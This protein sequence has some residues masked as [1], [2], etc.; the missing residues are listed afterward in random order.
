MDCG[1]CPLPRRTGRNVSSACRRAR[2]GADRPAQRHRW[3]CAEKHPGERFDI[4][5][6]AAEEVII[7]PEVGAELAA[8]QPTGDRFSSLAKKCS[9][10]E[11]QQSPRRPAMHQAGHPRDPQHQLGRQH[12]R[13]HPWLSCTVR[14]VSTAIVPGE[15][16][17]F[18]ISCRQFP[19]KL[20][21]FRKVQFGCNCRIYALGSPHQAARL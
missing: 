14:F 21:F 4:A 5:S 20:R 16:F 1:G 12:P 3:R 9:D 7:G 18:E 11:R 10:E 19:R 2:T 15:P 17:S 13:S 8:A 6:E